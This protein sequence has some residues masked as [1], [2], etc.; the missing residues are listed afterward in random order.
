MVLSVGANDLTYISE[1]F[2]I[3][4]T[5]GNKRRDEFAEKYIEL[6]NFINEKYG[7]EVD[8]FMVSWSETGMDSTIKKVLTTANKTMDNVY[9][10]TVKGDRKAS[11]SH[12]SIS[13]HAECAQILIDE[14]RKVKGW[15]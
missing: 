1:G 10:V 3:S 8:I 12:P 15:N 7:E 6:L 5:E 14:I 11:S 13:S 9:M 4:T 2:N